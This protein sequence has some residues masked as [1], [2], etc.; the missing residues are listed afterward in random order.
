MSE[1]GSKE[2]DENI[3]DRRQRTACAALQGDSLVTADV[4]G[5]GT[6][7]F[8]LYSAFRSPDAELLRLACQPRGDPIG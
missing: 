3:N 8:S 2:T 6:P 4:D 7:G 1:G 5:G